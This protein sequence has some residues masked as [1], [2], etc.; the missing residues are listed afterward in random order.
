VAQ[1]K[2]GAKPEKHAASVAAS[3]PAPS[4]PVAL[5]HVVPAP[6]STPAPAA[7]LAGAPTAKPSDAAAAGRFIVQVGAFLD[8]AKVRETRAKVEKLGMKTYT[9]PVET[10]TGK[11]IRVRVGPYAT[12]AEA[13]KIAARLKGDGLQA[14]VLTL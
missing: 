12:K 1:A 2:Q 14:V 5:P 6:A 3:A 7:I 9:Q 13:D 8:E 11:R 4:K 10:P